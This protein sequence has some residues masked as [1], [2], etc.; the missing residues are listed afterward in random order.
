[1]RRKKRS[2]KESADSVIVAET[3]PSGKLSPRVWVIALLMG[4]TFVAFANTL[5]N[6]FVYDDTTQILKNE[7][8]RDLRNLPKALVTEVWFWRA[9]LNQDPN[10]QVEPTTPYYRPM[11]IVQL[12]FT[13]YLFDK[14][15][16]GWHWVN[17]L[18]HLFVV[19]MAFRIF[20]KITDDLRVSAIAALLFAIHPLRVETVA[21]ISGLTDA[22]LAA[23][24]LPSFYLYMRFRERGR[25]RDLLFSLL[26]FLA[27]SFSKE[28]AV[29]MPLFIGAYELL[30]INQ[31]SPWVT[32]LK[33]ALWFSL[34]FLAISAFYFA[35]RYKALGFIFSDDNYT[36]H[37]ADEVLLTI[38]IA[39]WHYFRL[40][41]LPFDLTIFH[42]VP[43]VKS[44]LSLRFIL[45]TL[46]LVGL[47][48][49]LWWLCKDRAVRFA[50]LWFFIHLIPVLNLSAFSEDFLVQERYLYLP[51]LGFSLL[52]GVAL[53]RLP[54]E[55]LIAFRSRA[56]AQIVVVALL[57]VLLSAKTL[58]Q[59]SVWRDDMEFWRYG[60]EAAPE[61]KMAHYVLGHRYISRNDPVNAVI[62][63]EKYTALDPSNTIV[64]GNLASAH[65]LNYELTFDRKHVDRAVALCERALQL[66]DK[67]AVIY[68]TIGRA[69]TFN[70]EIQN[71]NRAIEYFTLGLKGDPDNP[72]INYHL[73]AAYH[74][75]GQTQIG[76][77]YLERARDL[78]PSLPDTY[79]FLARAYRTLGRKE[80]AIRTFE[81]YL[82]LQP[83]ARD[84]A[85]VRQ[86]IEKLRAPSDSP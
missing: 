55:K 65:L 82:Q 7:F 2:R 20:E 69:Y 22:Q 6:G 41:F 44:V 8:I 17:I 12:M 80:E 79:N 81:R 66:N 83:Q 4:V 5:N 76:L 42:G 11:F 63:L 39:I 67:T 13:W 14:E 56:T 68:D 54:V 78:E 15:A 25:G 75:R 77:T 57:I 86:E 73:G 51:S 32:R 43:M 38:P 47:G 85:E 58:A 33:S 62:S 61:Q 74:K 84:A 59:N 34:T 28:P 40:L 27:A 35:M 48:A 1:M 23:F 19:F 49:G 3:K 53:A 24:L 71:Y 29:A 30:L 45:P 9:E 10:A 26:L 46:G 64:L 21:W 16:G 37:S 72:M 60:A 18:M 36:Q 70:T 50:V 52:V 31:E